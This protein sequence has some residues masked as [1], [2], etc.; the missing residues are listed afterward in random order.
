MGFSHGTYVVYG[1]HIPREQY[2]AHGDPGSEAEYLD[3]VIAT[4]NLTG[5][6]L[7]HLL[8]GGYDRDELFICA[9]D[10]NDRSNAEIPLGEFRRLDPKPTSSRNDQFVALAALI[11]AAGYDLLKLDNPGWIVVP[12]VS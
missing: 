10:P 7:G 8:A 3:K 2:Q 11:V 5:R 1:V 6:G 9:D 12:D 4:P